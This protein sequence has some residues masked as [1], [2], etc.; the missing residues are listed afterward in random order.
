MAEPITPDSLLE[1]IAHAPTVVPLHAA[2][3]PSRYV[4]KGVLGEG[5]FGVVYDVLD[6]ARGE[7]LALKTLHHVAPDALVRFKREFRS[8]VDLRHPNLVRLHELGG[9][10]RD[11]YFTM[12]RIEGARSFEAWVDGDEA[13]LREGLR[14]LAAGLAALHAAGVLHRDLKSG[15]VLVDP[16]GRVVLVDFG[17]AREVAADASTQL[18]GTPLF[19]APEQCAQKELTAAIDLYALGVMLFHALSGRYPFDGTTL[20]MIVAKQT[21][22]APR[23][24]DVAPDAPADLAALADA[25]LARDPATRPSA[26]EVLAPLGALAPRSA[27]AEPFVGRATE[28]SRLRAIVESRRGIL[29]RIEGPSGIG[30]TALLDQLARDLDGAWV[31][32][33]RCHPRESVPYKAFDEVIDQLAR[34]LA[35]HPGAASILPRDAASLAALFPVMRAVYTPLPGDVAERA[36]GLAALRELFA[37][38]AQARTVVVAIDDLQWGDSDSARLLVELLRQPDA[39]AITI[40]ATARDGDAGALVDALGTLIDAEVELREETIPLGPL[41]PA[42]ARALAGALTTDPAR[43]DAIT[44]AAEGHP[45][46]LAEL[47]RGERDEDLEHL[48]A[49]RIAALHEAQQDVLRLVAVAGHVVAPEALTEALG[50]PVRDAIDALVDAK[51]LRAS[52]EGVRVY[53]DRIGEHLAERLDPARRRALRAALG[54]A[55]ARL[56][57][58]PEQIAAHFDAA[59]DP[60]AAEYLERAARR[61]SAAFAHRQAAAL[62]ERVLELRRREGI[63]RE[64]AYALERDRAHALRAAGRARDAAEAHLTAAALAPSAEA[65]RLR[66]QAGVLL[67][68]GGHLDRAVEVFAAV[69]D[70][71]G[72][73]LPRSPLEATARIAA[74]TATGWLRGRGRRAPPTGEQTE[75]LDALYDAYFVLMFTR[76]VYGLAAATMYLAEAKGVDSPLERFRVAEIEAL[77]EVSRRGAG[78]VD[79]AIAE[80]SRAFAEL[81]GTEDPRHSMQRRLIEGAILNFGMRFLE[82]QRALGEGISIAEQLGLAWELRPMSA[83]GVITSTYYILGDVPRARLAVPAIVVDA[84]E[85]D[86]LL[87]WIL[88]AFHHWWVRGMQEG[89]HIAERARAEIAE[90]WRSRGNELQD[91]WMRIADFNMAMLEGDAERAYAQISQRFGEALKQRAFATRFHYLEG[92]MMIGRGALALATADA[93]RRDKLLREVRAICAELREEPVPWALATALGLEAG[94]ASLEGDRDAVRRALRSAIAACDEAGLVFVAA[95]A[96]L[97][98]ADM[99]D[100]PALR[101][102]AERFF[103]AGAIIDPTLGARYMLPGR[104]R[105]NGSLRP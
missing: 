55:L 29:A 13:R 39:P 51:L 91:W 80:L 77:I 96:R 27:A 74:A 64:A 97:E 66:S 30:K 52:P 41:E 85:R 11:L 34:R 54:S 99:E 73:R 8:L 56:D 3:I 53:H 42:D 47:A 20:G 75:R 86:Q 65:R 14:Q 45:L 37:R 46:F 25:L 79:G 33:G 100:D 84:N 81:A 48:L 92:R 83:R 72:V 58:D 102:E 95:V 23:L 94:L 1:R 49:R 7:R 44:R 68:L 62:F 105:V 40:V 26:R 69:L 4:V 88:V 32:R 43:A 10:G 104:F 35:K 70:E 9:E 61:A 5:G 98:L 15:N 19:M 12:E 78:A 76:P 87:V 24:G 101:A 17:L 6:T 82:A 31:L 50:L 59:G 63:S 2:A 36:R 67:A 93:R 28:L 103:E 18:A 16:S 57:A 89:F 60:R 90:R 21:E 71:V 38:L 22:D